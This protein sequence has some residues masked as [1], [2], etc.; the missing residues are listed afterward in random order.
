VDARGAIYPLQVE[1]AAHMC[2]EIRR[3]AF[4][5]RAGRRVL[6]VEGG[7]PGI[8]G[9]LAAALPWAAIDHV[10]RVERIPTDRRHNAKIEYPALEKLV[11]RLL[12]SR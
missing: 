6:L 3:A 5:G 10:Q 4:L 9:R 8:E 2:E 1:A 7:S 11:A 12:R